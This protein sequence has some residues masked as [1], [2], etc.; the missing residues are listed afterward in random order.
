M[1]LSVGIW[2][3]GL[4]TLLVYFSHSAIG[5]PVGS[6]LLLWSYWFLFILMPLI[7]FGA[8]MD[9]T[10]ASLVPGAICVVVL[11]AFGERG[12][13]LWRKIWVRSP[14]KNDR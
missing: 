6:R 13:R 9:F 3:A 12:L 8:F 7:L 4:T 11:A 14:L 5:E 10:L 1:T 2:I